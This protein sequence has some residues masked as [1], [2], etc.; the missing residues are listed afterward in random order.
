MKDTPLEEI[1]I[2]LTGDSFYMSN[3]PCAIVYDIPMDTGNVFCSPFITKRCGV[4]FGILSD[5]QVV[6]LSD[7]LQCHTRGEVDPRND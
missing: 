4:K 3:I 5:E 7:F 2:F 1:D 6:L